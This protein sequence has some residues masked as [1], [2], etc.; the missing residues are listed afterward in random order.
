[1]LISGPE[2]DFIDDILFQ[3]L[4]LCWLTGPE[5][6]SQRWIV[7][8]ILNVGIKGIFHEIEKGRQEG[9]AEFL[10]VLFGFIRDRG[11]ESQDVLRCYGG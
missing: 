9:E 8:G 1:M 4:E 2:D 7:T 6:L 10:G 11:H 3:D 5:Q